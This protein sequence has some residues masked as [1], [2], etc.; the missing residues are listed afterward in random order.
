MNEYTISYS[1]AE[2]LD[3]VLKNIQTIF[4]LCNVLSYF[5]GGKDGV[6]TL[7]YHLYHHFSYF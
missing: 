6:F 5:S 2:I 4:L 1:A 3:T 7:K